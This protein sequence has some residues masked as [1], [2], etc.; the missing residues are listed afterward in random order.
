[1]ID[2]KRE[3]GVV[4][5]RIDHG[6]A[7]ALD[8]ELCAGLSDLLDEL[9]FEHVTALILTGHQRIFCAGV[10]LIRMLDG[11][12]E[13]VRAF[14]PAMRRAFRTLFS[15]PAPVIAAMNGH[16]VAGG[17]VLAATA[18]RRLLADS[19]A[20]VGIPE[21]KVG[22]PFPVEAIEVMRE[23]LPP[24][25]FRTLVFGGAMLDAAAAHDWGVVDEVVEPDRLLDRAREVASELASIPTGSFQLTK[26]QM[27]APALARMDDAERTQSESLMRIWTDPAT[28]DTVREYV[29]R[30]FKPK[31]G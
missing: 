5:L 16:A 11:G 17:C 13:Y 9:R 3:D 14:L 29:E 24:G 7:N 31:A 21:L 22:V 10:D 19:G 26:Q 15:F 18:D 1:M 4:L 12:P 2:T 8:L 27:R 6:K 25:R 28:F 23:V 30:T 20:R